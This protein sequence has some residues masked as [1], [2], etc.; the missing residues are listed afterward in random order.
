MDTPESRALHQR[1]F[2]GFKH[3]FYHY[4]HHLHNSC[5]HS[6]PQ[7]IDQLDD[8]G[9][10]KRLIE[11]VHSEY[12]SPCSP[13]VLRRW[14][15]D[16]KPGPEAGEQ[17]VLLSRILSRD[18][19]ESSDGWWFG[20]FQNWVGKRNKLARN[21]SFTEAQVQICVETPQ[22]EGGA[23]KTKDR[24]CVV[25]SPVVERDFITSSC[26]TGD[27][28]ASDSISTSSLISTSAE[29]SRTTSPSPSASSYGAS[30]PFPTLFSQFPRTH[31]VVGTAERLTRE[32]SSLACAMKKDGVD[33]GVHWARDACHD[34]LI[35]PPGWW[36]QKVTEEVWESVSQWAHGFLESL[37]SCQ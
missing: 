37:D 34:I 8:A 19:E 29:P 3:S 25:L 18:D 4:H 21:S 6:T 24:L 5:P 26:P 11:I 28:I 32:V 2:L 30:T 1:T 33:V 12:I 27:V 31:I 14:G 7:S 9:E 10:A 22:R 17:K 13:I 35:V 36:D 20:F 16:P 23:T 15:H